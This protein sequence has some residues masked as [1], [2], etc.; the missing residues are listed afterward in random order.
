MITFPKLYLLQET[1]LKLE[2]YYQNDI[3]KDGP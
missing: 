1:Y 3:I 2:Y